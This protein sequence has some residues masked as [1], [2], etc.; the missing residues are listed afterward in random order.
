M[1]IN[2]QS[3]EQILT[4]LWKPLSDPVQRWLC[5]TPLEIHT[6]LSLFQALHI[7]SLISYNFP[8]NKDMLT[9]SFE[10]ISNGLRTTY[11][12][13]LS[14]WKGERGLFQLQMRGLWECPTL[15]SIPWYGNTP[16]RRRLCEAT[17][18]L[19]QPNPYKQGWND[20]DRILLVGLLIKLILWSPIQWQ[21]LWRGYHAFIP[22]TLTIQS[23]E[24]NVYR[25]WSL[26][27]VVKMKVITKKCQFPKNKREFCD[28]NYQ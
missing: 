20:T 18:R 11:W 22:L 21:V 27:F 10:K 28:Y 3:S 4:L 12:V 13:A 24:W 23:M 19:K 5:Q 9:R 25:E 14:I 1:Y 7:A 15:L 2:P 8:A 6:V 17:P 26:S 16:G